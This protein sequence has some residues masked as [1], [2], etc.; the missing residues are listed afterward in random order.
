MQCVSLQSRRG[1]L[2]VERAPGRLTGTR[3]Q[4]Q[5]VKVVDS[6]HK[7]APEWRGAA[8]FDRGV[9]VSRYTGQI[10]HHI[11]PDI[12]AERDLLSSELASADKVEDIYETM[13]QTGPR[14]TA[15]AGRHRR[16]GGSS[17][18]RRP[19]FHRR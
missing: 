8:T 2:S 12:D 13:S 4:G 14:P 15:R 9:G 5:C 1:A 16:G 17:R 19:L 3:R 6:G 7:G 11:A 10:T 18:R